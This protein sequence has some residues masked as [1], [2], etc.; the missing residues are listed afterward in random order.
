MEIYEAARVE[1]CF[2][3]EAGLNPEEE[4]KRQ[5]NSGMRITKGVSVTR[6]VHESWKNIKCMCVYSSDTAFAQHLFSLEGIQFEHPQVV[7]PQV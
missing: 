4:R 3:L 1:S 7:A 2:R 6:D 5:K